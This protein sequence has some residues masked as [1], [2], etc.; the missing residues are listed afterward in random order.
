MKKRSLKKSL[1][2]LE[3]PFAKIYIDDART[4]DV[5]REQIM[6]NEYWRDF[7]DSLDTVFDKFDAVREQA[8]KLAYDLFM[9]AEDGGGIRDV[10]NEGM[11]KCLMT[12]IN[13]TKPIQKELLEVIHALYDEFWNFQVAEAKY[14]AFLRAAGKKEPSYL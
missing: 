1:V 9:V 2:G 12:F 4:A 7:S 11:A 5:I 10:D 3:L 13:R 6:Q 8:D 14:R